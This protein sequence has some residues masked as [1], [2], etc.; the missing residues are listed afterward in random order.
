[1]RDPVKVLYYPDMI[2]EDTALKKAVLFFDEIHFMDRPSFMF[3]GGLGTIGTQSRLRSFEEL[4][5]RDGVPLFVHE[6]PGGPVQGDFLAMVAADVNDLNF[7][8]DFQAGL[9]SSPTFSQHVVQEGKYPDI[10]TKELHT[11]ETLRD[12]FSKV[13]LSNVLTQFENPMSLLTD[14]SVRPFGLT[15]PESIAKTLI[16][17]AAVLSTHLNHALTVGANEGFIPFAD[18]APYGNLFRTKYFRAMLALDLKENRIPLT[19]L[20]FEIFDALVDNSLLA[21]M[22]MKDVVRYR[23]ESASAREAFLEYVSILQ[24]KAASIGPD[25][26]YSEVVDRLVLTEIMP[27]ARQFSN[28]L[29]AVFENTLGALGKGVVGAIGGAGVIEL[30]GDL[31][32][33]KIISLGS[34]ASAYVTKA[35]IDAYISERATR[36]E[37]SLNYILSID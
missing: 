4:F 1:M 23:R 30:L 19:D 12:E 10:D 32:L 9:R 11:A 28:K 24:A 14:K 5:R 3:E 21:K 15:K 37:C 22:E 20:S 27:A 16:F 29:Q 17:Q 25:Q 26:T 7:L 6:A 18:A 13:D 35:L 36:R 33:A 34:V 8:R 2:P 31:S